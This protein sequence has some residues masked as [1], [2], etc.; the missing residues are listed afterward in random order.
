[1]NEASAEPDAG[2]DKPLAAALRG[3]VKNGLLFRGAGVLPFGNKIR[4]V[5][6]RMKSMLTPP[7]GGPGGLTVLPTTPHPQNRIP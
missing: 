1:V 3:D 2:V 6:D 7:R 5:G 4:S